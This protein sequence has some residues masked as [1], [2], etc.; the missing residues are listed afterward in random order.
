MLPNQTTRT[1]PAVGQLLSVNHDGPLRFR[2]VGK[3]HQGI[4][5]I[6]QPENHQAAID[7]VNQYGGPNA[8]DITPA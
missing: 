5:W 1:A 2:E 6:V 3:A 8:W 7:M 4:D